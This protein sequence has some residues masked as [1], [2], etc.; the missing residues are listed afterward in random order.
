MEMER[1]RKRKRKRKRTINSSFFGLCLVMWLQWLIYIYID[2][3]IMFWMENGGWGGIEAKKGG[4]AVR[5]IQLSVEKNKDESTM[6]PTTDLWR[7]I[8]LWVSE[9]TVGLRGTRSGRGESACCCVR[10]GSLR[11]ALVNELGDTC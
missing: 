2:T 10:E 11:I 9:W 4:G 1:K 5:G 6:L 3:Y 7:R 8:G